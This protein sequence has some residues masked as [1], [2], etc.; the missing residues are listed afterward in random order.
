MKKTNY[1][2][3]STV[4]ALMFWLADSAVHKFVYNE[5]T[6]DLFPSDLHEL[7]MRSTIF[8]LISLLG[9]LVD[10]HSQKMLEQTK[11]L[12]MIQTYKATLRASHQV[13]NNLLNQME[14]FKIEAKNCNDFNKETLE[15]LDQSSNKAIELIHK[16]SVVNETN[17]DQIEKSI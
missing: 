1:K 10:Y 12:E 3:I 4:I 14:Y 17:E 9:F 6:F 15:F 2:L 8:I 16:L 11:E 13:L 5:A 7:W